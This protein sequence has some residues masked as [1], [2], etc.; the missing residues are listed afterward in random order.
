MNFRLNFL[1]PLSARL[2]AYSNLRSYLSDEEMKKFMR[3]VLARKMQVLLIESSERS[4]LDEE[5]RYIV[6]ADLCVIC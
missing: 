3:D 4:V 5:K 6:D 1:S 2:L